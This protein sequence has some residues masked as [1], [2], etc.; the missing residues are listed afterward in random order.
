M[1][2]RRAAIF[3]PPQAGCR[4][5]TPKTACSIFLAVRVGE[6]WG[7]R[8]RSARLFLLPN[9]RSHLCPVLRLIPN[10]SHN[11]LTLAPSTLAKLTN[12][13]RCSTFEHSFQGIG[14]SPFGVSTYH[15]PTV[16]YVSEHVLPISPV[17]TL[18]GGEGSTPYLPPT[19]ARSCE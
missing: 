4:S 5:R 7:R 10:L 18:P 8:D 1:F 16:T 13:P 17:C 15:L 3:R 14:R 6:C 2:W 19:R 12:S 9:R 11:W